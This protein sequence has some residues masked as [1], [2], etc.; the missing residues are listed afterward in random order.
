MNNEE[1]KYNR[2]QPVNKNT[3][4]LLIILSIVV[5]CIEIISNKYTF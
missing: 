3:W 5:I 2:K 1:K 4:I